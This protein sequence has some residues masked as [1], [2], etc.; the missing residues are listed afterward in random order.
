MRIGRVPS[1]LSGARAALSRC[2]DHGTDLSLGEEHGEV[3][4]RGQGPVAGLGAELE[5]CPHGIHGRP[6]PDPGAVLPDVHADRHAVSAGQLEG[7]GGDLAALGRVALL[8]QELE[9]PAAMRPAVDPGDDVIDRGAARRVG[10]AIAAPG[11]APVLLLDQLG[12]ECQAVGCPRRTLAVIA[13]IASPAARRPAAE[14]LPGRH[15][16]AAHTAPARLR[17]HADKLTGPCD[18]AAGAG[19]GRC[20]AGS[21]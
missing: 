7:L 14:P 19:T 13:P 16:Q 1:G 20:G 6:A 18:I 9:I 8:V 11:A 5:G 4:G 10:Q 21:P 17:N 15:R 3:P 12:H 2:P